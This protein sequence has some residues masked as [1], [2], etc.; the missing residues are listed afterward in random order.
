MPVVGEPLFPGWMNQGWFVDHGVEA[1]PRKYG[2]GKDSLRKELLYSIDLLSLPHLLRYE[3]RNSM[4]YSIES[5]VPF[6]TPALAEYALSLPEN[7]LISDDGTTKAVFRE[8]MRGIVPDIILQREKV[9]FATPEREWLKTLRPWIGQTLNNDETKSTPFIEQDTVKAVMSSALKKSGYWP[10]Y[11]WR[12]L[13]VLRWVQ[14][15]NVRW[16]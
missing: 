9:G 1:N 15:F 7:C 16:E 11:V 4:C 8:A 14:V 3:D 10:N 6:C 5:R 12:C 2:R 13:N